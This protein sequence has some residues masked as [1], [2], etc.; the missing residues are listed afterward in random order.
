MTTARNFPSDSGDWIREQSAM[1]VVM[2]DVAATDER[3]T[4]GDP[5]CAVAIASSAVLVDGSD[6]ST[7]YKT[8]YCCPDD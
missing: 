5:G 1:P 8:Q 3:W 6:V 4:S 2:P 7:R